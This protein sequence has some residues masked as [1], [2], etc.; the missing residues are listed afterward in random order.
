M[1]SYSPQKPKGCTGF[2]GRQLN[3]NSACNVFLG[4]RTNHR[5]GCAVHGEETM[6]TIHSSWTASPIDVTVAYN[7]AV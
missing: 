6:S 5:G 3:P 2:G 4:N 1:A 7:P